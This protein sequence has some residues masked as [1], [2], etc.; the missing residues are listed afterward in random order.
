[1]A[2][3]LKKSFGVD[4]TLIEGGGGVFDVHVNGTQVWDKHD[5]GRFPEHEEVIEKIK[6]ATRAPK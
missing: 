2:E 5:V 3:E 1:L 4:A 6:A